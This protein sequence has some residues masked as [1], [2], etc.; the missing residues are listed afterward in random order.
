MGGPGGEVGGEGPER[1]REKPMVT[2]DH[3]ACQE[4]EIRG[5]P[6]MPDSIFTLTF[7]FSVVVTGFT[8]DDVRV[9]GC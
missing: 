3:D 6:Q 5:D 9:D 8:T 2:I 7:E 1:G 4:Y